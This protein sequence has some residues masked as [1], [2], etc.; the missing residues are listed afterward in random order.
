VLNPVARLVVK[1]SNVAGAPFTRTA[2][3]EM[4]YEQ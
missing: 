3:A 4:R 1:N 2:A